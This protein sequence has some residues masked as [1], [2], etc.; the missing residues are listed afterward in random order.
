MCIHFVY[1]HCAMCCY[2]HTW[3]PSTVPEYDS[4]S[5]GLHLVLG[6]GQHVDI[7][8][9]QCVNTAPFGHQV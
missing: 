8:G 5:A 4:R 3:C 7:L 9:N 6:H 1:L 2:V